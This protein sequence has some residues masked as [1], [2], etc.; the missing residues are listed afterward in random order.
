[1]GHTVCALFLNATTCPSTVIVNNTAVKGGGILCSS[2]A[3]KLRIVSTRIIGNKAQEGS[4]A[5]LLI[6]ERSAVGPSRLRLWLW[7]HC[8]HRVVQVSRQCPC[9]AFLSSSGFPKIFF[10]TRD[11]VVIAS[12][13]PRKCDPTD[14]EVMRIMHRLAVSLGAHNQQLRCQQ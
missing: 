3:A 2:G 14:D 1:M 13:M 12:V 5:G 9:L 10:A 11:T 7:P 6:V 8:I 4:S